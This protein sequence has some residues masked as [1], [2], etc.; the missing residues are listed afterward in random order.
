MKVKPL[1]SVL[2]TVYNREKY[3][4]EAIDS[5]INSS[6]QNWELI[7]TD[8]CSTDK[9]FTIAKQ[10]ESK[11]KR[12]KVY[13]NEKNL[14]Q[15]PNRNRAAKHAKGK[16][17]KYLDSD[18]IIYPHG[19]EVMVN[20]ME[21]FPEAGIGML[22]NSYNGKYEIPVQFESNKSYIY[23]FL[24]KGL[25]YIGP[26]GTIIKREFFNKIGLFKDYGIASD[27]EFNLRAAAL[28]PSVFFQR[29]L[30]WWRQHENQEFKD[31]RLNKEYLRLNYIINKISLEN[32]NLEKEL[33]KNILINNNKL[34]G[35]RLLKLILI[36]KFRTFMHTIR[37]TKLP[38]LYLIRCFL[39]TKKYK[40]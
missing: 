1:V 2:M 35:R 26:S 13:K 19:L 16:Y 22:F 30:I 28:K 18:D 20:A 8:N 14:G 5:V 38:M 21:S 9:S 34:M 12:I 24:Y 36:F 10:Y 32:S 17:I 7:V 27:Y 15:F 29:D 4:S 39:P 31:S 3:I 25:L 11:Y 6:Y 33:K 40:I 37:D 23:H